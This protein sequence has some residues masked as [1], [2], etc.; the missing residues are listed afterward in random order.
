MVKNLVSSP[1]LAPFVPN[2]VPQNFFC[3]FYLYYMLDI[4]G[5]YHCM[6]FQGTLIN[7]SWENDKK[8]SFRADFGPFGKHLGPKN[9]FSKIW[10]CQSLDIIVIYH[11]VQYQKKLMIQFWE[12]LV[13]DRWTWRWMDRWTDGLMDGWMDGWMD[14]QTNEWMHRQIDPWNNQHTNRQKWFHRTLSG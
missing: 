12:N 9:C 13:T 4:V 11:H 10:L 5:S 14:R 7:Q 1:I 3:E 6:Q 2:F 8:P